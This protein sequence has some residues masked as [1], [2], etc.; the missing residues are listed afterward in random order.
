MANCTSFIDENKKFTKA[1][2]PLCEELLTQAKDLRDR[3]IYKGA[4]SILRFSE[5]FDKYNSLVAAGD[6]ENIDFK[7]EIVSCFNS[8]NRQRDKQKR[9]NLKWTSEGNDVPINGVSLVIQDCLPSWK[10]LSTILIDNAVK[11]A[12][13]NTDILINIHQT[14]H[15]K[16]VDITNFG[17]VVY[18]NETEAILMLS[19]NYRGHNAKA[20]G[21]MGQGLGLKLA[22]LI[23]MSHQWRDATI[24]A[25]CNPT[26]IS[27][28]GIPYGKFTISVSIKNEAS[29][30]Q[31]NALV[32]NV[33]EKLNEFISHEFI[34]INPLL[35]QHVMEILED[36][37]GTK[38]EYSSI[39]ESLR[40]N[41]YSLY[42]AIMDHLFQC[43]ILWNNTS[44][45]KR[46][47]YEMNGTP[48]KFSKQLLD[49]VT[50]RWTMENHTI[51]IR[52]SGYFSVLPMSSSL[53][54]F[55]YLLSRHITRSDYTGSVLLRGSRYNLELLPPEGERFIIPS[56]E[57]Q[58]VMDVILK[59]NALKI[60]YSY[61]VFE[62]EREK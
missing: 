46:A 8:M 32:L 18:P 51:K 1:I 54:L 57:E 2:I 61:T 11:Y 15:R 16:T 45:E 13:D 12:P 3:T 39:A 19:D 30:E 26:G 40:R 41:T 7:N 42:E 14:E 28:N 60:T 10:L 6:F 24:N 36:S 47:T 21:I 37:F 48:K 49:A 44:I 17:P 4:E 20:S 29:I 27:Y 50:R 25:K 62:I 22:K 56:D 34:R 55:F 35:S 23:I 31:K 43:E 53:Y 9:L 52:E 33:A 59:E 58:K 38:R 5:E